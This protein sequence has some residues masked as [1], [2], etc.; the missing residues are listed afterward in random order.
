MSPFE[1]CSPARSQRN[2]WQKPGVSA[3]RVMVFVD[4]RQQ[5]RQLRRTV[6]VVQKGS[7]PYIGS[8][9]SQTDCANTWG[10]ETPSAT[11]ARLPGVPAASH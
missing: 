4:D 6:L 1:R 5:V 10:P 8:N 7:R 2:R 3:E 9:A 11:I